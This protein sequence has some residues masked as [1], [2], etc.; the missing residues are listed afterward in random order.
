[1]YTKLLKFVSSLSVC[2][3]NVNGWM[4]VEG[5]ECM[6]ITGEVTGFQNRRSGKECTAV[7]CSI[8]Y[9]KHLISNPRS[10]RQVYAISL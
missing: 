5:S 4:F 9:F 8:C 10:P 2:Q 1:M 7:K 3:V 6:L